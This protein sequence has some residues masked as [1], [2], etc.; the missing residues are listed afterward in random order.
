MVASCN[1]STATLR[2]WFP[3]KDT[4]SPRTCVGLPLSG[5][6]IVLRVQWLKD[7]DSVTTDY[8]SL[9][10]FFT[11]LGCPIQLIV[12]IPLRPPTAL[13]HQIKHMLHNQALFH[14]TPLTTLVQASP[15]SLIPNN[16][17]QPIELTFLLSWFCNLFSEP[18]QL[19]PERLISHHIHL[20]PNS[21]PITIKPY[22]Y[23]HSQK[24][25]L[26]KQV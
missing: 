11:H 25:E 14:I 21:N 23:P 1:A 5:T 6:N 20:L 9:S 26:E 4:I 19:P 8:I 2:S 17:P 13:V 7:L 22:W 3:S 24:E 10:M 18:T 16:L 15:S 12:D